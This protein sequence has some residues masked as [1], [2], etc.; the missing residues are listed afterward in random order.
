M[1]KL[2]TSSRSS[3]PRKSLPKLLSYFKSQA[4]DLN[5]KPEVADE[6]PLTGPHD[7][8]RSPPSTTML[9]PT[10]LI[11][12]DLSEM[13]AVKSTYLN[14]LLPSPPLLDLPMVSVTLPRPLE[15]ILT[16]AMT[17]MPRRSLET[18]K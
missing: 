11:S 15:S 2:E 17:K 5:S 3:V 12:C 14:P 10:S 1:P 16:E 9:S 6:I 8:S 13:S 18:G 7:L 4:S